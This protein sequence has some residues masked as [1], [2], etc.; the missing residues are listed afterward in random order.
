[1]R[2]IEGFAVVPDA[3]KNGLTCPVNYDWTN[4]THTYCVQ[5]IDGDSYW[6]T[7]PIC[8]TGLVYAFSNCYTPA[9]QAQLEDMYYGISA[10]IGFVFA[11][12]IAYIFP[13]L[14][15][16]LQIIIIS[17]SILLVFA[18][19][20]IKMYGNN[21]AFLTIKI[22]TVPYNDYFTQFLTICGMIGVG[23]L[24]GGTLIGTALQP[25]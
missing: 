15:W 1:M 6:Y 20:Y 7:D 13:N 22:G 12:L 4:S 16:I 25:K 3:S 18:T 21:P 5:V 10:A 19:I 11:L 9:Q 8:P 2:S 23:G 14:R 24:T 17:I